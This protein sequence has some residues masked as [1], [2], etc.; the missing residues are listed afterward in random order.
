MPKKISTKK[1]DASIRSIETPSMRWI[2]VPKP[3]QTTLRSLQK[4]FHFHPL[5]I[6]DCLESNQ[7]P[8]LDSYPHYLFMILHF[9]SYQPDTH[10]IISSEIRFFLYPNALITVHGNSHHRITELFKQCMVDPSKQAR[11]LHTNPSLLVYE[12]LEGLLRDVYPMLGHIKT[13]LRYI[14]HQIFDGYEKRM[15]RQI[16]QTKRNIVNFRSIMQSHESVIQKLITKSEPLF[17][18]DQLQVYYKNLVEHTKDIWAILGNEKETIDALQQTNESLISFR[19]NDIM[20]LLTGMSVVMLPV[21]LIA[22]I[23][24]MNTPMPFIT[25]NPYSFWIVVSIMTSVGVTLVWYFK[26]RDWL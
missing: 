12:L 14:E 1:V 7:Y 3:S 13:D 18:T 16:L 5:D 24:T 2:D 4:E 23:V 9:P 21:S 20:K 15:V 11:L 8:K 17:S 6:E 26:R 19:L 22:F 10:E 25:H